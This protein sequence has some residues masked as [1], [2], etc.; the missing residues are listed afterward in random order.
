MKRK[1][2]GAAS[3]LSA[4]LIVVV[5]QEFRW[6]DPE[7][8]P[9]SPDVPGI[10]QAVPD[11]REIT[12]GRERRS[13]PTDRKLPGHSPIAAIAA[14]NDP[15][16]QSEMPEPLAQTIPQSSVRSALQDLMGQDTAAANLLRQQLVRR[17]AEEDPQSAAGWVVQHLDNEAYREAVP[18]VAIAW[19]GVDPQAAASWAA[20]LPGT[21]AKEQALVNIGYEV[22][23]TQPTM[24]LGIV[25]ALVPGPDRDN[26]L[27][28]AIS[29]WG[30]LDAQAANNW[31]QQ[32]SE[33]S[34]R[35]RLQGEIA[36]S[37]ADKDEA[38]AGAMAA[39]LAPGLDQ[40][41]AV[42]E[43]V[44]RWAQTA[45]ASA[46]AWIVAFPDTS[47]R[48]TALETLVGIWS[49]QDNPGAA[50]W[51]R[52]LSPGPLRDAGLVALTDANHSLPR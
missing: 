39:N 25:S 47:L 12:N 48:Q 29:Q 34:L 7:D 51:V 49:V 10:A 13:R 32:I 27:I 4:L 33:D 15:D 16:H 22:A 50:S 5:F 31:V 35:Q 26:L 19:A 14:E 41:R 8:C 30:S 43:I 2:I 3:G 20:S 42:V 1:I 21:P 9:H 44:Q 28:H 40:D 23:G 6:V 46:G 11:S 24:A 18:Q 52:S 17:W 37:L 38:G 36:V 45:P